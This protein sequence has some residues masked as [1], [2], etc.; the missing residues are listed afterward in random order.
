[1]YREVGGNG[2]EMAVSGDEHG[3]LLRGEGEEVVVF[4]IG[5][6]NCNTRAPPGDSA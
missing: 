6:R 4:G 5:C 3:A 2:E 1:V